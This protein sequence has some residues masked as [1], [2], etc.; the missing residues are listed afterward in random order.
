MKKIMT[1]LSAL[2]LALLLI[3]GAAGLA[4]EKLTPI[5]QLGADLQQAQA[6]YTLAME[7]LTA[8]QEKA[9]DLEARYNKKPTDKLYDQ[10]IDAM[11]AVEDAEDDYA[12]AYASLLLLQ[13]EQT[14]M[15]EDAGCEELTVQHKGKYAALDV[16]V[17]VD[18]NMVI[19]ALTAQV[20][21]S[22]R[23]KL[24]AEND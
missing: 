10:V 23:D 17:W 24:V 11:I 2:L 8:A 20:D 7:A 21:G 18:E 14:R 6:E 1:R 19:Y 15:L 16:S 9:L 12:G 5:Q 3:M 4:A 22:D 13:T